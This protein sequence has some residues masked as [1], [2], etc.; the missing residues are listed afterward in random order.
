MHTQLFVR[1]SRCWPAL[2]NLKKTRRRNKRNSVCLNCKKMATAR[3]RF[4]VC[5]KRRACCLCLSTN[6]GPSCLQPAVLACC[7]YSFHPRLPC[8]RI[9]FIRFVNT[10]FSLRRICKTFVVSVPPTIW[11]SDG[12]LT[13]GHFTPSCIRTAWLYPKV[14][15]PVAFVRIF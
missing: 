15:V 10:P 13:I 1:T 9:V 3:F 5:D 12:T 7:V 4:E 6:G 8:F 2:G 14:F 11:R